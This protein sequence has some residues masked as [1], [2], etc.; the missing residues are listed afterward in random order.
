LKKDSDMTRLFSRIGGKSLHPALTK[1]NRLLMV[2]AV[3]GLGVHSTALQAEEH[4]L[5]DKTVRVI[6]FHSAHLVDMIKEHQ[7]APDDVR[8]FAPE[9]EG[10]VKTDFIMLIGWDSM[11]QIPN[12]REAC[13]SVC[14]DLADGIHLVS[15]TLI[16]DGMTQKWVFID[17]KQ[18]A[19]Q[20]D[21]RGSFGLSGCVLDQIVNEVSLLE[22]DTAACMPRLALG[23]FT[24]RRN[25]TR[26]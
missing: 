13:G 2:L 23:S 3:S 10:D 17:L 26:R 9:E 7:L 1:I 15:K 21:I 4:V 25:I 20:G 16:K 19:H 24:D 18:L 6:G 8:I 14:D 12:A 11:D 22:P 5:S